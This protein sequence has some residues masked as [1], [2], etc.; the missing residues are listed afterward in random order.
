MV[1][2]GMPW[3]IYKGT[4]YT[5]IS[6]RDTINS[7][8][9]HWHLPISYSNWKYRIHQRI[10]F[11]HN[12]LLSLKIQLLRKGPLKNILTIKDNIWT[13][14]KLCSLTGFATLL[15]KHLP[16]FKS[17]WLC[18]LLNSMFRDFMISNNETSWYCNGS[19]M[20]TIT[21]ISGLGNQVI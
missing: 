20:T 10:G 1:W 11:I 2:K 4:S 21:C 13:I 15:I 5:I 14:S 19:Q 17:T 12:A 7:V 18:K 3:Q 8:N 6:Q 16:N 9:S